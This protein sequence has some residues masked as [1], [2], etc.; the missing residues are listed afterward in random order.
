MTTGIFGGSFNPLHFGHIS[1]AE[2]AI[3]AGLVD[4]VMLMVSPQNPLK[5]ANGLAP[6]TQRLEM[7]EKALED[8]ARK[9]GN[10]EVA[11]RITASDFEFSLERPTYTWK[12]IC[13]LRERFPQKNFAIIIGADNWEIIH[14]W[15]NWEDILRTV[16]IIVYPREGS[17][18]EPVPGFPPPSIL[19]AP[20]FPFSSTDI[21]RA[22]AEG[23][24]DDF[25]ATMVPDAIIAR[26]REIYDGR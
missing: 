7:A 13:C 1:L 5:A 26:C 17:S 22:I 8:Y 21:R 6:E 25:L 24:S 23:K 12:T 16:P 20:L 3:K 19:Q 14:R 2:S 4:E 10:P 18:V 11:Q 15:R 9:S